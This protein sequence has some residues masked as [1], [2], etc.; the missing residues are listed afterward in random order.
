MAHLQITA[1]TLQGEPRLEHITH[2]H[3]AFGT[4]TRDEGVDDIERGTNSFFTRGAF[5]YS[6]TPIEVVHPLRGLLGL[7]GGAYL[8]SMPNWTT[9]DNLLNLPRVPL[10]HN[11]LLGNALA[12][13][14][15]A[16]PLNSLMGASRGLLR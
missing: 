2:I 12:R 8:R 1:V 7:G 15:S 13:T 14:C 6:E 4:R 5:M 3:G 10:P 16:M 9:T 11:V